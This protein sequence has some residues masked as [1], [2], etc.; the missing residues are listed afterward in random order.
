MFSKFLWKNYSILSLLIATLLWA[1]LF[2]ASILPSYQIST[3]IWFALFLHSLDVL[4]QK[5]SNSI[6]NSIYQ[7]WITNGLHYHR[8]HLFKCKYNYLPNLKNNYWLRSALCRICM[9][10]VSGF[11]SPS[12]PCKLD[13][14]LMAVANALGDAESWGTINCIAQVVWETR[15]SVYW[16]SLTIKA[17]I[18]CNSDV[19]G[20][21]ISNL[22]LV[23]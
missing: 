3:Y 4:K 6:H 19:R 13:D 18:Y 17:Q 9:R 10:K 11:L 7:K 2:C 21:S 5:Q 15:L 16:G 1:K 8:F 12:T 22:Y 20:T 14:W 23:H